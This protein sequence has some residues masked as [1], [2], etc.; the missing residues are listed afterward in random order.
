MLAFVQVLAG[1]FLRQYKL[2]MDELRYY[3]AVL[4]HRESQM[5][6]YLIRGDTDANP[7]SAKELSAE[8]LKTRDFLDMAPGKIADQNDL[9]SV[10][11]RMF[12][13]I[14]SLPH[15]ISEA[16]KPAATTP[17]RKPSS[18]KPKVQ[19]PTTAT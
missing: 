12:D 4:R 17:R 6:A 9:K 2:A 1:F 8:L 14:S 5:L 7:A 3:E 10:A 15:T 18:P 11:D 16:A 19:R 13:M